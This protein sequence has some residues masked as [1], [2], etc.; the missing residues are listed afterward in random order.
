MEDK[1]KEIVEKLYNIKIDEIVLGKDYYILYDFNNVTYF[2]VK[3]SR[4]EKDLEELMPILNELYSLGRGVHIILPTKE[5]KYLVN[6]DKNLYVLLQ[7]NGLLTEKFS[8]Y[9]ILI[10][11]DRYALN[12]VV[13]AKYQNN[14]A[15]LWSKKID[16]YEYQIRELGKDKEEIIKSFSYFVGLAEDAIAY[17]NMAFNDNENLKEV[18]NIVLAHRRVSYPNMKINFYNPLSFIVDYEV[19]DIGGYVKSA[20][21]AGVDALDILENFLKYR[22]INSLEAKL[23]YARILYPSYYFDVYEDD[24]IDN[25]KIDKV[26]EITSNIT[27]LE[28]FLVDVYYLINRYVTI[29]PID[30]LIKKEL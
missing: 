16:Y 21:W 7:V 4:D 14:W 6:V 8:I 10:D 3:Y 29:P 5:R 19:R 15:D 24:M 20:F 9:D 17:V 11:N 2:W 12:P 25:E 26:V 18:G 28:N 27:E 23:L 30:W 13:K 22:K 1:V